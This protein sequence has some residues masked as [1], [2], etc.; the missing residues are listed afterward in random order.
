MEPLGWNRTA[1]NRARRA[2][3]YGSTHTPQEVTSVDCAPNYPGSLRSYA[4]CRRREL[5]R[6]EEGLWMHGIQRFHHHQ[7]RVVGRPICTPPHPSQLGSWVEEPGL[8]WKH[9]ST[10]RQA[11]GRRSRLSPQVV[12]ARPPLRI[13][14]ERPRFMADLRERYSVILHAHRH[15]LRDQHRNARRSLKHCENLTAVA[16]LLRP[17]WPFNTPA[18]RNRET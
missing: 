10:G 2:S 1:G 5:Y 7:R 3:Q 9:H 18:R 6:K 11:C 8:S 16:R 15:Q 17:P 14:Q 13:V 4:Q 12:R